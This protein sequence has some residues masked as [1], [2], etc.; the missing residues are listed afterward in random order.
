MPCII[1]R[2][3]GRRYD[4]DKDDFCPKCGSFNPPPDS[5]ATRL[6][7]EMLARFQTG[8]QNQQ[9]AAQ[10]RPGR[11]HP[12][13]GS[14]PEAGRGRH[15][16]RIRDCAACE[17]PA[18]P[19]RKRAAARAVLAL[20]A[21]AALLGACLALWRT[22]GSGPLSVPPQARA[23]ALWETFSISGMEVTVEDA[24]AV[25]GVQALSEQFG[26][27][28]RCVAVDLWVEG[29][30][31]LRGK[32]F[33]APYLILSDGTTVCAVDGD[34]VLSRKLSEYGVYDVTL[35]DAQWDDPLY[36]QLVFFLP[37]GAEG[38]AE[39]VLGEATADASGGACHT[40]ALELP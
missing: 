28:P 14:M 38:P 40:V 2:D 35:S 4:Y 17:E 12:T 36:G 31:V 33:P 7:Q 25:E 9:R 29:G 39:L 32:R 10:N 30:Q 3:C 26:F 23:H 5:D 11:G 27:P 34:P 19:R 37:A 16:G 18:G 20:V 21:A 1:C 24:W 15:A 13:R 6:E 22:A 8:Q